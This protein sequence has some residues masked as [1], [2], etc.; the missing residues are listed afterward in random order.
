M[1]VSP[2]LLEA[3]LHEPMKALTMV[4]AFIGSCSEASSRAGDTIIG[5]DLARVFA[6]NGH[7]LAIAARS[8]DR[9]AALADEIASS[10]A[11]RPL[12]I[13][14]DLAQAGAADGLM[15]AL[16]YV[17]LQLVLTVIAVNNDNTGVESIDY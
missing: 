14:A 6:R 8:G 3:S 1:M 7:R 11:P 10:G 15:D 5:A 2:A 9:L 4:N 16:A 17:V 13:E 12:L